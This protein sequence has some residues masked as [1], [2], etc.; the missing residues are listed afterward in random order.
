MHSLLAVVSVALG[1]RSVAAVTVGTTAT[2]N[3]ANTNISPDGFE[4]SYVYSYLILHL[5]IH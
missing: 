2:L 3:V 5:S 4:R 1:L